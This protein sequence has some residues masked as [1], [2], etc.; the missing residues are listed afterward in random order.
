VISSIGHEWGHFSGARLSGAISPVPK[1]PSRLYFMFRFDL[2]QNSTRQF[3]WMSWG[4]LLGSWSLVL[5]ALILV[6]LD[7]WASAMLISVLLGRAVNA[8]AFEYPIIQRAGAGVP[9][10]EALKVQFETTGLRKLPGLVAGLL[11]FVALS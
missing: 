11:A 5:M 7:S 6:P 9:P 3:L 4:G 8:T 10:A 1:K 2:E